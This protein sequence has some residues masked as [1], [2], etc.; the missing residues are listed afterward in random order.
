ML[1]IAQ[2]VDSK[3]ESSREKAGIGPPPSAS[4]PLEKVPV[5][6]RRLDAARIIR[7]GAV[8]R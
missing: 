8:H 5:N 6:P 7:P 4:L 2:A 3:W 1:A